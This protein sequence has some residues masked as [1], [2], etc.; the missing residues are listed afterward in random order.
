MA[1]TFLFDDFTR[2]VSVKMDGRSLRDASAEINAHYGDMSP[3]TLSRVLNN[4]M[5]D[6]DTLL[7]LCDWLHVS[8][9]VFFHS[10]TEFSHA[11]PPPDTADQVRA[12]LTA[13]RRL[14]EKTVCALVHLVQNA[15]HEKEQAN[16]L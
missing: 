8:P 14:S 9:G 3:S 7:I 6:M 2:A 1:A 10:P 15:L 11:L 4:K 16:G 12:L 13:D 5:P